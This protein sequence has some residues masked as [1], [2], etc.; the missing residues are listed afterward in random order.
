MKGEATPL[1]RP[2]FGKAERQLVV[3]LVV[4]AVVVLL[5]TVV[6]PL[7]MSWVRNF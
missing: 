5:V 7:L 6:L 1:T 4:T 2:L 3:G